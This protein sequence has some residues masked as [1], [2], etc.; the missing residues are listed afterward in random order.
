MDID[1]DILKLEDQINAV[2]KK[3]NILDEFLF[4][5]QNSLT[6]RAKKVGPAKLGPNTYDPDDLVFQQR[7]RLI[8]KAKAFTILK[9]KIKYFDKLGLPFRYS[10]LQKFHEN[11]SHLPFDDL[12]FMS[13]AF[14]ET[15][16]SYLLEDYSYAIE[17]KII[18]L[19]GLVAD[20]CYDF[21]ENT[22]TWQ[23]PMQF[24]YGFGETCEASF[25]EILGLVVFRDKQRFQ[26]VA[27]NSVGKE[28]YVITK[29]ILLEN[30][31]TIIEEYYFLY[32]KGDYEKRSPV[33][34][35]GKTKLVSTGK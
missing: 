1:D 12:S 7:Y 14:G 13:K 16:R 18:P 33:L 34:L 9:Q 10:Y 4:P 22:A 6:Y 20:F 30:G 8:A 26:D 2:K 24:I 35:Q 28:S 5:E 31:N 23:G 3:I 25:Q 11:T 15:I 27:F 29:P 17:K 19:P 21:H 32:H